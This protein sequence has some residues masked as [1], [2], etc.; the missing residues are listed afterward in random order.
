M[1]LAVLR[2]MT[3]SNLVGCSMGRSAGFAPLDVSLSRLQRP[4]C[5][6]VVDSR[7]GRLARDWSPVLSSAM[8]AQGPPSRS[9]SFPPCALFLGR[10]V[11]GQEI[12]Q[13]SDDRLFIPWSHG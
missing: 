7:W 2:L 11:L 3:S 5:D 6:L 12:E 10:Y 4:L 13:R 8:F 9:L 1:A